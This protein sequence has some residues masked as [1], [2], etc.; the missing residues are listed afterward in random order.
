[1]RGQFRRVWEGKRLRIRT[2]ALEGRPGR[3]TGGSVVHGAGNFDV[4]SVQL[5]RAADTAVRDGGCRRGRG[6]SVQCRTD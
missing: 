2:S 6:G 4:I 3:G 5:S 1:M